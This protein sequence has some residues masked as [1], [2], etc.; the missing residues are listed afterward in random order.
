M[1]EGNSIKSN[2]HILT[3]FL[4]FLCFFSV[5]AP[6]FTVNFHHGVKPAIDKQTALEHARNEQIREAFHQSFANWKHK[7][8]TNPRFFGKEGGLFV[9]NF[10]LFLQS[11]ASLFDRMAVK[12]A[13]AELPITVEMESA[14]NAEHII[15]NPWNAFQHVTRGEFKNSTEAAATYQRLNT[16]GPLS[17]EEANVPHVILGRRPPY[18]CGTRARNIVLREERVFVRVHGENNQAR[19]WMMRAKD[20]EGLS[21]IEIQQKY[22]LPE[23]PKYVSYVHVPAGTRIRVGIA[24]AQV[25]WGYGGGTQYELL[26]KIPNDAFRNRRLLK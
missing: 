15:K 6:A 10:S 16:I 23:L 25:D 3:A 1:K 9:L 24:G 22:A 20:I 13:E 26:E 4:L 18:A 2:R 14:A 12:A 8:T 21:P 7:M 17:A 19:S 11:G 5:P